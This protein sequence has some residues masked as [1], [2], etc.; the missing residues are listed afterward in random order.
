MVKFQKVGLPKVKLKSG[1]LGQDKIKEVFHCQSVEGSGILTYDVTSSVIRCKKGE[2][3]L[4]YDQVGLDSVEINNRQFESTSYYDLNRKETHFLI[5]NNEDEFKYEKNSIVLV[6]RP[7]VENNILKYTNLI[8]PRIGITYGNKEGTNAFLFKGID[9]LKEVVDWNGLGDDFAL[10]NED[11]SNFEIQGPGSTNDYSYATYA[12]PNYGYKG[13]ALNGMGYVGPAQNVEDAYNYNKRIGTFGVNNPKTWNFYMPRKG[14]TR[15]VL[16]NNSDMGFDE[17]QESYCLISW[18]K[19]AN[20][21][22]IK[23]DETGPSIY[24]VNLLMNI[25]FYRKLPNQGE[26]AFQITDFK[27]DQDSFLIYNVHRHQSSIDSPTVRKYNKYFAKSSGSDIGNGYHGDF[28]FLSIKQDAISSIGVE[29]RET[30]FASYRFNKDDE[31]FTDKYIED[32]INENCTRVYDDEYMVSDSSSQTYKI[33]TEDENSKE[34]TYHLEGNGTLASPYRWDGTAMSGVYI[35]TNNEDKLP[36]INLKTR[37][38]NHVIGGIGRGQA[39][40]HESETIISHPELTTC[41]IRHANTYLYFGH[42]T[43]PSGG[44]NYYDWNFQSP[45]LLFEIKF[46]S[47]L[48]N[49]MPSFSSYYFS[50]TGQ[51]F[52]AF[53]EDYN[54]LNNINNYVINREMTQWNNDEQVTNQ[55]YESFNKKTV[56]D[57]SIAGGFSPSFPPVNLD[58]P[59]FKDYNQ[60]GLFVNQFRVWTNGRTDNFTDF[61]KMLNGPMTLIHSGDDYPPAGSALNPITTIVAPYVGIVPSRYNQSTYRNWNINNVSDYFDSDNQ[62]DGKYKNGRMNP[63]DRTKTCYAI[64]LQPFG[65]EKKILCIICLYPDGAR[66][67]DSIK[68]YDNEEEINLKRVLPNP[69]SGMT[70]SEA[71]IEGIPIDLEDPGTYT[72]TEDYTYLY[73]AFEEK[74][75]EPE[76]PADEF[77]EANFR[78][79]FNA[80][81]NVEAGYDEIAVTARYTGHGRV[82][83][84]ELEGDIQTDVLQTQVREHRDNATSVS[85][86]HYQFI[87]SATANVT[88]TADIDDGRERKTVSYRFRLTL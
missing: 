83:Y 6:V 77:A 13:H 55:E 68:E 43:P 87:D 76:E 12:V 60:F 9:R 1:T 3:K 64:V 72:I 53:N 73:V 42:I 61:R 58:D 36:Y 5:F 4:I 28:N 7:L 26:T 19:T 81:Y 25:Y 70:I 62:Y 31:S 51:P 29:I 88:V 18:D 85:T 34:T 71:E 50:T 66:V 24:N 16:Y 69:P 15:E 48:F 78:V 8:Q 10:Y 80:G 63:S 23:C 39:T 17:M 54:I 32:V 44:N 11:G 56:N 14:A 30:G 45:Q 27:Y 21:L 46:A 22:T 65:T 52:K 41:K 37:R 35:Y 33:K 84:I 40:R 75:E 49:L 47:G 57:L 20:Q 67:L 74:E 59:M 79:S 82:Y 86:D 2:V 38:V